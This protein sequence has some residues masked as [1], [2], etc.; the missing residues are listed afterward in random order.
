MTLM[1]ERPDGA[2]DGFNSL[3]YASFGF[4]FAAGIVEGGDG[5]VIDQGYLHK[6]SGYLDKRAC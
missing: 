1:A 5:G 6:S 2:P 4:R 3:Q